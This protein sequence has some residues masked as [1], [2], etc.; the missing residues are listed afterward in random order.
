MTTK[1]QIVRMLLLMYPSTWRREYGPE[2]GAM[3][4]ERSL[5]GRAVIN[6]AWSGLK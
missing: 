6:V 3:L 5:G 1:E 4:M 2:L